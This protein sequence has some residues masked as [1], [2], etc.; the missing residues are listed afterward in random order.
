MW[1]EAGY[2]GVLDKMHIKKGFQWVKG[3]TATLGSLPQ[4]LVNLLF[5]LLQESLSIDFLGACG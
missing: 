4:R 2:D 3:K 5:I 1:F